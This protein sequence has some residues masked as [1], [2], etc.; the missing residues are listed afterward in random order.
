MQAPILG[1]LNDCFA[2]V[3]YPS[4]MTPGYDWYLKEWLATLGKKQADIVRDL[5]WNKAR[6]SLMLRGKQPYDRDSINELAIYLNLKPHELLMHPE[7]AMAMRRLKT[8]AG[9]IVR[10]PYGGTAGD[11]PDKKRFRRPKQK[12]CNA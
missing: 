5:G 4:R 8:V 9:E 11:E 1:S 7:D 12:A 3:R 2:W 6:I 10:I